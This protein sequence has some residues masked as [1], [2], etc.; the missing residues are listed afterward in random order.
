M[1]KSMEIKPLCNLILQKVITDEDK[2]QAGLTKV[3]FRAGMV[4]VLESL[5]SDKLNA[6]MTIFQKNMR[7]YMA[8]KKYRAM[9]VAAI[10]IQTWWRG[11][12]AKKFVA[13]VRREVTARRLQAVSRR[14]IQRRKFLQTRQAVVKFQSRECFLL[15][16][17]LGFY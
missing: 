13:K 10:K 2:Y 4:A 11:V 17:Y 16:L 6:V 9:R 15:H 8:Q 7:R 14:F 12:M 1:I 3:F 5:R